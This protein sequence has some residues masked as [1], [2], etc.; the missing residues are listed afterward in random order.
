MISLL[1][2]ILHVLLQMLLDQYGTVLHMILELAVVDPRGHHGIDYATWLN[3]CHTID[4]TRVE[5]LVIA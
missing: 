2:R 5:H 4:K 1:L 3:V